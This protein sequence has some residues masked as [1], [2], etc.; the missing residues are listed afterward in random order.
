MVQMIRVTVRDPDVLAACGVADL[1]LIHRMV[2]RPAAEIARADQPRVGDQDRLA[3]L[4]DLDGG[5]A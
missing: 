5:I 2:E 3:V 1:L 4:A